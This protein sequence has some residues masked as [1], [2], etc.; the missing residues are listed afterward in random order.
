MIARVQPLTTTRAIRGPF[1]YRLASG[2]IVE[3]GS[4]LR[5]PFARRSL[6][7]VVVELAESSGLDPDRLAEPDAVVGPGIGANLVH[8]AQ[9]MAQEYC[10]TPA[11]A[12]QL[13][14]APGAGAGRGPRLALV[15]DLT[16]AGAAH[17][18]SGGGLSERQLDLLAKLRASGPRL[19]SELGTESLRRL[20]RRGLVTV[21]RR[22]VPRR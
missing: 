4:L 6:L 13:M 11:R 16:A 12:L 21:T 19:A 17:E 15:A 3:V 5:I 8:L 22:P 20:E 2:Q 18:V 14:I 7:G 9:W 10:S 1:D